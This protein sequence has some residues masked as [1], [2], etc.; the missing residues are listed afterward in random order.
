M[1]QDVGDLKPVSQNLMHSS[2]GV[3]DFFNAILSD[4]DIQERIAALG[5]NNG[6]GQTASLNVEQV[7]IVVQ[8]LLASLEE[9]R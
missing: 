9:A 8:D 5:H 6:N 2:I 3:T 4:R 7:R 1:T